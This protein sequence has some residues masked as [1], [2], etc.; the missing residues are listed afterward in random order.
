MKGFLGGGVVN[1]L[2]YY[3]KEKVARKRKANPTL[4]YKCKKHNINRPFGLKTAHT[5]Y[6]YAEEMAS[7][8]N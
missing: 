4:I 2:S 6:S 8:W 3:M 7:L 1:S 5:K